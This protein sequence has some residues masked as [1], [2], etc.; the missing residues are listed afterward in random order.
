MEDAK[1][2]VNKI[3]GEA[4]FILKRKE[5]TEDEK[6]ARGEAMKSLAD[7]AKGS[8]SRRH[9]DAMIHLAKSDPE[10]SCTMGISTPNS[11]CSTSRTGRTILSAWSSMPHQQSD[12]L[13]R[14]GGMHYEAGRICPEFRKFV[15]DV[16]GGN[17]SNGGLP[18]EMR[19]LY[20]ER[21]HRRT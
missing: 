13:T 5:E 18:T 12:M 17:T 15:L 10:V 4:S 16:M 7:W 9:I 11:T 8:E 2:T 1:D 6:K 3:R 14:I 20:F 19:W 21:R